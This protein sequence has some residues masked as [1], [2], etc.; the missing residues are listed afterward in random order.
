[1]VGKTKSDKRE[2]RKFWGVIWGVVGVLVVALIVS[3]VF[4]VRSVVYSG[5]V[6]VMVAPSVAKV[7]VGESEFSAMGEY[8]VVPGEYEVTVTAEGFLPKTGRLVVGEGAT[9][10]V[11]LYLEPVSGN[12][13]WYDEH[14]GDALVKGEILN[15]ATLGQVEEI[16]ESAPVLAELPRTVEYFSEGY[17]DYV[18]YVISYEYDFTGFSDGGAGYLVLVK[19]YTGGNYGRAME[20]LRPFGVREELVRYEDLSTEEL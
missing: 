10:S 9:V 5:K 14:P 13:S 16:L 8:A 17:G 7:K 3:L 15:N 4:L 20:W 2:G 11:S 18:K 1:M 6:A 19:D 12:E